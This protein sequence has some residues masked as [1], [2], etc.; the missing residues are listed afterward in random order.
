MRRTDPD[1]GRGGR[2]AGAALTGFEP[3][4]LAP[5]PVTRALYGAV[6]GVAVLGSVRVRR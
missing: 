5:Y 6:R 2:A 4:L 3:F 1:P